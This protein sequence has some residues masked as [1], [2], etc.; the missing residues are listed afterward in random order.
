MD[1][2]KTRL[3][4]KDMTTINDLEDIEF[5]T[6][7]KDFLNTHK[8][9]IF[10][11]L[12]YIEISKLNQTILGRWMYPV[13]SFAKDDIKFWIATTLKYGQRNVFVPLNFY[14]LTETILSLDIKVGGLF[15]VRNSMATVKECVNMLEE[16]IYNR[17]SFKEIRDNLAEN[18]NVIDLTTAFKEV[19]RSYKQTVI[20]ES[21]LPIILKFSKLEDKNE[22]LSLYHYLYLSLPKYNRH[23]LEATIY[24]LYL[25]HDIATND[26]KDYTTN[27][28]MEGISTVMMPNI[29][30]KNNNEVNL[31]EVSILVEFMKEFILNF[32]VIVQK[33]TLL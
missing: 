17:V 29:L 10:N 7:K 28:D 13:V 12:S 9:T 27:M 14:T 8:T 20:P 19:L 21:F 23:L 32:S 18:F 22:R 3:E 11:S 15:R 1:E 4:K 24:F 16:G 2:I 31:E 30:L 6:Y 25:V 26:G 33:N 5:I